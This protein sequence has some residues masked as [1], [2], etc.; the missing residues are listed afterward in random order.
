MLND[1]V[2]GL[3]IVADAKRAERIEREREEKE[4]QEAARQSALIE[5]QRR[6][7]EERLRTLERHAY[8]G[9]LGLDNQCV[10]G[11]V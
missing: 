8:Y 1:V 5:Q 3:A 2:R 7:E 9:R 6:E 4:R 11:T 10:A